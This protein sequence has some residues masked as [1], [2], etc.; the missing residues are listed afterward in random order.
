VAHKTEPFAIQETEANGK[1]GHDT[2]ETVQ[3]C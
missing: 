1:H 2:K 3:D